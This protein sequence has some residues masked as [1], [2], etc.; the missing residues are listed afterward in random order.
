[1]MSCVASAAWSRLRH[2]QRRAVLS[3]HSDALNMTCTVVPS[4]RV[5]SPL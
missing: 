3:Y 2:Q 5:V 4:C 1:M